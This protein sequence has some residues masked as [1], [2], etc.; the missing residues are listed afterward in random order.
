MLKRI[1]VVEDEAI[2]AADIADRLRGLGYEVAGTCAT[3]EAALEAVDRQTPDLVLMDI[4]IKG[5][6]DG[7][8]A[9]Q[10][11][12]LGHRLPVVYL[13]AH[14]D[15]D[16][17]GRAKVTE[18]FGYVVKP[19]EDRELQTTIEIG[20]HKHEMETARAEMLQDLQ[21]ALAQVRTLTG[22]LP[23]CAACK[24]VR[25]DEGYWKEVDEYLKSVADADVELGVCPDCE[26]QYADVVVSGL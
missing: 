23:I 18:P 21:R 19:F 24:K 17:L 2:I 22:L 25:D 15:D 1:L 26:R 7:I 9:A 12:R 20:L 6:Q 10:Q 3:A 5:E 4:R 14:A 13:T 11:I 16:T 8:E